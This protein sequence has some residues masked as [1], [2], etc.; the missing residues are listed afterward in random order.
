M[1]SF[2]YMEQHPEEAA[3]FDRAMS[4]FTRQIAIAVAANYD[5]SPFHTIVDVGGGE[6]TLLAG[7][8][9]ANPNLRGILFEQP[10]VADRAKDSIRTAGFAAR[11]AVMAGGFFCAV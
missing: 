8:L 1:D 3:N 2:S 9:A 10:H 4:D 7:I 6:G 5:F 11:W